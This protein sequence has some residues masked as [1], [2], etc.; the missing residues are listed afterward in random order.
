VAPPPNMVRDSPM[1]L[2]KA[3]SGST[4]PAPM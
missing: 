4:S 1:P 2:P 3:G